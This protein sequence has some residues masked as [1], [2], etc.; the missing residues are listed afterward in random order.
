VAHT[1]EASARAAGRRR[2]ASKG[3]RTEAAILDAAWALLPTKP[4]QSITITDLTQG[5]GISRSS[6][7]F[8]FDSKDAVML[9]LA[10]RVGNDIRSTITGFTTGAGEPDIRAG[11]DGYLTRWRELGP[12]LRAMSVAVESDVAL[13]EFWTG[14]TDDILTEMTASIDQVRQDAGAA[15]APASADLAR[16]LFGMLWHAGRELSLVSSVDAEQLRL[17]N[18]LTTVFRRTLGLPDS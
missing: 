1:T 17:G 9:A 13:R 14:I 8:Y 7:Y 2:G 4:L 15:A 12:L 10:Q 6:F 11:I 18:T 16:V 5:A 3:D